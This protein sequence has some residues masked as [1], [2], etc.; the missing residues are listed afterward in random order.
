MSRWAW[1]GSSR[2]PGFPSLSLSLS[3]L[4][5]THTKTLSLSSSHS[6]LLLPFSLFHPTILIIFTNILTL[7]LALILFTSSS[8]SSY[9]LDI[10]PSTVIAILSLSHDTCSSRESETEREDC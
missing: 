1:Q 10:R 2:W 6:H 3:A 8:L 4:A 5:T 9:P 7:T